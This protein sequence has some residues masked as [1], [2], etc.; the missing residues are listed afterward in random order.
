MNNKVSISVKNN[1]T[2]LYAERNLFLLIII[3]EQ[4]QNESCRFRTN[5]YLNVFLVQV[6]KSPEFLSS[7][8]SC[9][10]MI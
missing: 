8:V 6:W 4:S 10:P 5:T 7:E 1:D 2:S 3:T 9:H